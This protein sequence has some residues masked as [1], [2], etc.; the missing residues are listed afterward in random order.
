[1]RYM[2]LFGAAQQRQRISPETRYFLRSQQWKLEKTK[3]EMRFI[4]RKGLKSLEDLKALKTEL[5]TE[6]EKFTQ[7]RI[8]LHSLKRNVP[9]DMYA[10]LRAETD[11]LTEKMREIRRD[12]R[13]C[14]RVE[15]NSVSM[16]STIAKVR[17]DV[18][19]M[20]KAKQKYRKDDTRKD[21]IH[22]VRD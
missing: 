12:L 11:A 14:E 3:E 9:D 20:D 15:R 8:Y 21:S 4:S 7:E 19:T 22:T 18:R 1:M 5:S 6:I 13:M 2:A 10:K 17:A 16:K